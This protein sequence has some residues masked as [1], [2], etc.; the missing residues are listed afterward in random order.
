MAMLGKISGISR[1]SQNLILI[2]L[3]SVNSSARPSKTGDI[4]VWESSNIDDLFM[5]LKMYAT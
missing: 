4:R 3:C 1:K 5:V 2:L